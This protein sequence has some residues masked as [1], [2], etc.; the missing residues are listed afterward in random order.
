[1]STETMLMTLSGN[2][3]NH[4]V[5]VCVCLGACVCACVITVNS[6]LYE[7]FALLL[8]ELLIWIS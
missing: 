1:M 7:R 5:C 8:V 2:V 4:S 6:T 3:L